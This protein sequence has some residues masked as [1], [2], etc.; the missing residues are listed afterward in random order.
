MDRVTFP[1]GAMFLKK[2]SVAR[3]DQIVNIATTPV[4]T[5]DFTNVIGTV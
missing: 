2:L 5:S 3:I 4:D 1:Y